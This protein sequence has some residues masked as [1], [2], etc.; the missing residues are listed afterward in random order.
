M[1]LV[2]GLFAIALSAGLSLAQETY[3]T[4]GSMRVLTVNGSVGGGT[5]GKF[6]LLV[7]LTSAHADVFANS[8]GKGADL[9]FTKA[10]LTTRYQH[11]IERWDSLGQKAEIWVL[12]DSIPAGANTAIKMLWNKAG[13]ADSS[14]GSAVF[15]AANGFV[16][17]LHLGDST[18]TNPRPNQVAGAPTGILRNFDSLQSFEP[19]VYA[20]IEGI[21][22]NAD[23]LRGGNMGA[24]FAADR[25]YIDLGHRSYAGFSDF[26]TGFYFSTW[27]NV[28]ASVQYERFIELN[29]D[30]VG[31]GS[32]PER[33]IIFGNHTTAAQ[34]V[35]IR[36]G[37]GS[38]AF[39]EPNGAVYPIGEWAHL[40][41]SK[42]AGN[43]PITIY[44]NGNY[45]TE[46]SAVDD[47][48]IAVREHVALGRPSVTQGDPYFN[49]K[50]DE[51]IVA[52]VAR[53]A[54]W[55]KL[56]YETQKAA[57]SAVVIGSTATPA[58]G[59]NDYTGIA[60][61]G[62]RG[63]HGFVARAAGRQ[64]SFALPASTAGRVSIVDVFGRTV[65]TRNVTA[66]TTSITWDG[67]GRNGVASR[68]VYVA[69]FETVKGKALERKFAF[70]P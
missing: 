5:V 15:S 53:S 21:V 36:W 61:A 7:R 2:T 33:I 40:A 9:R 14:K 17:V 19:R 13:A 56:S 49:G 64:V 16:S 70:N 45:V 27:I 69:R 59:G 4:W 6:P 30:T 62:S 24:D 68:G 44:A 60:G 31:T 58:A 43:A 57:S 39:N 54:E 11:Q 47:P 65:W 22:G 52:N 23:E 20:P 67:L 1:K 28:T 18:G 42:P 51:S 10:N 50:L 8:K 26:S 38:L 48:S 37:S 29:D 66:G 41:F 12:V 63:T 3:S 25:D 35:S 46:T 55:I 32:S 34:N